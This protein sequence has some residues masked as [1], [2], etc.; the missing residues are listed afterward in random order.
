M[1]RNNRLSLAQG[2][3]L[4]V[5]Q[6]LLFAAVGLY[7]STLGV[8]GR[9]GGGTEYGIFTPPTQ[10]GF[11]TGYT[12]SSVRPDLTPWEQLLV[13][14]GLIGVWATASMFILKRPQSGEPQRDLP[15]FTE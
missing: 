12:V 8:S 14:I 2:I 13:W 4:V 9:F 11:I 10:A 5:A 7:V 3:I 1:W 6:A 15:T